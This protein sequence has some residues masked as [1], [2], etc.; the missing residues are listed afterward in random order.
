MRSIIADIFTF[1]IHRA[2]ILFIIVNIAVLTEGV[3]YLLFPHKIKRKIEKSPVFVFR[4][5]GGLVTI[6]GIVLIF[7]Y[8]FILRG[9]FERNF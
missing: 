8:L 9:L 7:L 5:F 4:I 3:L 6:L 1:V 2:E